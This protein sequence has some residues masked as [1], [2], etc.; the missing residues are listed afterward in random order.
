MHTSDACYL[1]IFDM[2]TF[3]NTIYMHRDDWKSNLK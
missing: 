2:F 1:D 3:K